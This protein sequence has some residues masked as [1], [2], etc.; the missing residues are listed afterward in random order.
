MSIE[1]AVR[2]VAGVFILG[3]LLLAKWVDVRFLWFTAFVGANL[4]QSAI[5]RLCPL[6]NLFYALGLEPDGSSFRLGSRAGRQA[7]R[8]STATRTG[9]EKA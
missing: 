1:R 5:T 7:R 9:L 6:A 3:S 8:E 4:V 2:A